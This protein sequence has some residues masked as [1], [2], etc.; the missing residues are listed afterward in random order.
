M[1]TITDAKP[2]TYGQPIR[3]LVMIISRKIIS[4]SASK[5]HPASFA[6][7]TFSFPPDEQKYDNQS[8][9][10][11]WEGDVKFFFFCFLFFFFF[12]FSG[13]ILEFLRQQ[14]RSGINRSGD[15]FNFNWAT[16]LRG[17]VLRTVKH[18]DKNGHVMSLTDV[19]PE[20]PW[21][22]Q[23]LQN[24][25]HYNTEYFIIWFYHLWNKFD[26]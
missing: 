7:L 18:V 23:S 15:Y 4:D 3:C 13:R 6:P 20:R 8:S 22:Y 24:F 9:G 12:H 26:S 5:S 17:S 16:G 10:M 2:S 14:L 1:T 25:C 21:S 11:Q 19:W